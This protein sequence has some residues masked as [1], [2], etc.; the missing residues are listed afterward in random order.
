VQEQTRWSAIWIGRLLRI[1]LLSL[2]IALLVDAAFGDSVTLRPSADTSLFGAFPDNNLGSSSNLV[3]GANGSG[4]PSRVLIR[5]DLAKQIPSNALI[6]SVSFTFNVVIL[7]GGGG[8]PS[9]FDLRTISLPWAEGTGTGNTGSA[10]HTGEATWNHRIHPSVLWTLPGGAVSNDFSGTVSAS[11]LI[12]GLGSYTFASTTSLVADVQNWLLN[13]ATNF[14][15]ALIGESED[16][17]FTARRFGSRE[18]TTNAPALTIAYTIPA[19]TE[20]QSITAAGQRIQF[21]FLTPPGQPYTVQYRPSA[22]EGDWLT[23]TNI[24]PQITATNAIVIDP[25]PSDAQRFYRIAVF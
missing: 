21:S 5:F 2:H 18:D 22:T 15:W 8:V 13:P 17:Q 3:S 23:L 1:S 24:A 14:G 16:M 25:S 11:L 7:P 12:G 10:A 19:P 4:L 20:I 9:V 6:Q